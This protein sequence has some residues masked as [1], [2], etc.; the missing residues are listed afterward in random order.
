MSAPTYF[1][2]DEI[3]GVISDIIPF[4]SFLSMFFGY[5]HLSQTKEIHFDKI[6]KDLRISTFQ[7]PR[8]PAEVTK[9]RGFNVSSLKP[10]YIKD[11]VT[12]DND[13]VFSRRPGQLLTAP[14]TPEQNYA[15]SVVDLAAQAVTRLNRRLEWMAAQ[16]FQAG[17]YNMIGEDVNVT[18]DFGR[19]A[20]NTITPTT[21]WTIANAASATPLE[22]IQDALDVLVA[23]AKMIIVG[24]KAW[25]AIKRDPKFDKLI[26]VN[27]MRSAETGLNFAPTQ[28]DYMSELIYRGEM[29]GATI[30][31]YMGMYEHPDTG[32][33]TLY[34]PD[35]G[36]MFLPD[37][38]Y[39]WQCYAPIMDAEANYQAMPYYFK[40]WIED[41]PGIPYLMLQS[42]PLLAHTKINATAYIASGAN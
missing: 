24:K 8:R 2:H 33:D 25:K 4:Q 28:K 10:G 20:A 1:R 3:S 18:V 17:S 40:N 12:V 14:L 26:Y 35:D 27:L 21:L 13:H 16:L 22:D 6:A 7:G 15:A 19:N 31:T 36:V 30:Y 23:P 29:A 5:E 42:A 34:I 38:M 11:K 9:Q 32:T 39:G 37:P 41:D